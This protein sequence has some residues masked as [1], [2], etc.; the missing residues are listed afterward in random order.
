[1][2][3]VQNKNQTPPNPDENGNG[4]G[5]KD[6]EELENQVKDLQK[7]FDKNVKDL[8]AVT[9]ELISTRRKAKEYKDQIPNEPPEEDEIDKRIDSRFGKERQRTK[10]VNDKLAWN[11]F[12][13]KYPSFSKDNDESGLR[14][15][16]LEDKLLNLNTDGH[17][18]KEEIIDDLENA[19]K[20]L[21]SEETLSGEK[22]FPSGSTPKNEGNEPPSGEPDKVKFSDADLDFIKGLGLD[23]SVIAERIKKR[24]G[25]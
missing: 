7:K 25:A 12:I 13:K 3:N 6:T 24:G 17:Y 20:L 18:L 8:E 11:E 10:E 16:L 22:I 2:T 5:E 19:L 21:K 15:K 23:P 1:M 14:R 9:G 4:A